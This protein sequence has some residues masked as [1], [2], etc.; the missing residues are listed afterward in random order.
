[1]SF[2]SPLNSFKS[3]DGEKYP[4]KRVKTVK[5]KCFKK[6]KNFI[7]DFLK[8]VQHRYLIPS[9]YYLH[10]VPTWVKSY[11]N[12][13]F[14]NINNWILYKKTF[15]NEVFSK[16]YILLQ[17]YIYLNFFSKFLWTFIKYIKRFCWY[18]KNFKILMLI[19]LKW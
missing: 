9:R 1:M 13:K 2:F 15:K 7:K 8:L 16:C 11:T 5:Y 4:K 18:R 3:T 6:K 14:Y 17:R 12:F 19:L 10:V